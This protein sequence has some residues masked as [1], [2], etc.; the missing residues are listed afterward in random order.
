MSES[1]RLIRRYPR[2]G[3]PAVIAKTTNG[4]LPTDPVL[5]LALAD[6]ADPGVVFEQAK[7]LIA[8]FDRMAWA[9]GGT[10]LM[11]DVEH[12]TTAA[13]RVTLQLLPAVPARGLEQAEIIRQNLRQLPGV[14]DVTVS[15]AA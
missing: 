9:S 15:A 14:T 13:G 4:P 10:G 6:G 8:G 11:L 12:S 1:R 7:E 3:P 5:T 2:V